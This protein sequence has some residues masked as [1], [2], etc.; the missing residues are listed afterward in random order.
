MEKGR[1]ENIK[2]IFGEGKYLVHGDE[3]E[4]R[5]KGGTI[6]GLQRKGKWRKKRRKF[7]RRG[8]MSLGRR[9]RHTQTL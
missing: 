5:R 9:E 1:K 3:E 2:K 8:K 4:R 7:F 6:F